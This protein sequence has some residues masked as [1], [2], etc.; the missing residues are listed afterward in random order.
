MKKRKRNQAESVKKGVW[1][2]SYSM[3]TKFVIDLEVSPVIVEDLDSGED[4]IMCSASNHEGRVERLWMDEPAMNW[5]LAKYIDEG[6]ARTTVET[7]YRIERDG[8]VARIEA[9]NIDGAVRREMFILSGELAK[10]G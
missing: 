6:G 7:S 2:M 3:D 8:V 10:G 4:I 9:K 5:A 1:R